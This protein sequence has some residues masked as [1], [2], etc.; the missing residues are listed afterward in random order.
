MIGDSKAISPSRLILNIYFLLFIV[1]LI[2]GCGGRSVSM[3]ASYQ[4]SR[5]TLSRIDYTIQAGVFNNLDNAV[6]LTEDLREN[7]ISAYYF[8]YKKGVY[9]V[10]F[11][12][13]PSKDM[14]LLKAKRLKRAGLIDDYYV[15]SP[16]ETSAY[17][18]FTYGDQYLRGR[19]VSTAESFL[20]VPYRW[21]GKSRRGFDCS[22]L[23]LTVY[24][25]N[26]LRLP[27]T[28]R[29]QYKSGTPVQRYNLAKGDL[30]FFATSGGRRVSHVGIYIGNGMF[31]HAPSKG[32]RVRK[33]SLSKSYYANHYVGA[34]RYF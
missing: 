28:S 27:R 5:K 19:I 21:G 16:E 34:R 33:E 2:S 26:G 24:N 17:R 11:G 13:Y 31:I 14:A 30:V 9:K 20:G 22:G 10:R 23:S 32:K 1:I 18:S 7:G 29:A 6:R 3:P 8:V 12:D 4:V 15:V 25:I